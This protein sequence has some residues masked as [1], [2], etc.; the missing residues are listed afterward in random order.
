MYPYGDV[1]SV[2]VPRVLVDVS[3]LS[4]VGG[5]VAGRA[6]SIS[7]YGLLSYTF[8]KCPKLSGVFRY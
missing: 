1:H 2:S 3:K 4:G 8:G 6:T 7:L 5:L